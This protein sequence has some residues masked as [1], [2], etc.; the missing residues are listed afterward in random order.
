MFK[1]NELSAEKPAS[2]EHEN[3]GN[4]SFCH[5]ES[6]ALAVFQCDLLGEHHVSARQLAHRPEAQTDRRAAFSIDLADVRHDAW[7]NPVLL[8]RVAT[9]DVEISLFCE[10]RPLHWRQPFP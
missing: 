6:A 5:R 1:S 10:L 8:A 2:P 9:D 4:K 7:I 3:G